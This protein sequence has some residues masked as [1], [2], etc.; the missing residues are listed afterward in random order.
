M[1]SAFE[2]AML[3]WL[4]VLQVIAHPVVAVAEAGC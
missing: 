2:A 3:L 1:Q 4:Q